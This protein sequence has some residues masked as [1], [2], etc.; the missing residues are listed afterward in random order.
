MRDHMHYEFNLVSGEHR[1]ARADN[2]G[3]VLGVAFSPDGR[4][5]ARHRLR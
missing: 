5:P 3:S 2:A 1:R 4:L